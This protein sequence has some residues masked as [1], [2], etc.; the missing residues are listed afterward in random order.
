MVEVINLTKNF[1]EFAAV[2]NLSFTIEKRA[3]ITGLLGPN[4]AGKTTTM[5]LLTGYYRPTAGS[6]EIN[7]IQ[8]NTEEELLEIKKQIGYLPENSPLYPEMLVSEY[9]KFIGEV[10]GL[11]GDLLESAAREMIEKLELGSHLYT[12]IGILSKGYRQRVA[13]AA[14]L[15]HKPSVIILD[16]PTSGLD[17]NQMT[18]IRALIKELG[19]ECTLILS[20]HILQE[21]E[22]MC[23]RVIIINKGKIVT[24]NPVAKLRSVSSCA[25]TARGKNIESQLA[26][27]PIV[28]SCKKIET[29]SGSPEGFERFICELNENAPEKLFTAVAA[30]GCDVREFIQESRSLQDIFE[31]MTN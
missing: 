8:P 20:T 17:P 3:G 4:G 26:A 10:R 18:H 25:V 6:I 19:K 1:G 22:E 24:D 5:R 31:E 13:L 12:P 29:K 14:T 16:E 2:D 27:L 28:K 7:G 11:H 21:V 15:I 9:L 30:I 23:D